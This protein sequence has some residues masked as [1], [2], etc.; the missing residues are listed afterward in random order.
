MA[1]GEGLAGGDRSS[2]G[3][4]LLKGIIVREYYGM[5]KEIRLLI[6]SLTFLEKREVRE[7]IT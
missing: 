6:S 3:F 1:V 7:E 2:A 5:K 4:L